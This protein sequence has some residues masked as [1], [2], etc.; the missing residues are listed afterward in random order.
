MS[1]FHYDMANPSQVANDGSTPMDVAVQVMYL[2]PRTSAAVRTRLD[3]LL[4]MD[5]ALDSCGLTNLHKIVMGITCL[6]L[7]RYLSSASGNSEV[8]VGD[9]ED[10]TPLLYASARGDGFAVET[11]LDAGASPNACASIVGSPLHVACRNGHLEVVV[12]LLQAGADVNARIPNS[13]LTPLHRTCMGEPSDTHIAIARILLRHGVDIEAVDGYQTT[14]LHLAAFRN[15][16][17]MAAFLVDAGANM[18][19]RDWE[20]TDTLGVSIISNACKAAA[21]LLGNMADTGNVDDEGCS[22]LHY[23]AR[24]ANVEM[25]E[26]FIANSHRMS[27]LDERLRDKHDKTPFQ[28]FMAREDL[29]DQL[30]EAFMRLLVAISEARAD[31]VRRTVGDLD[32]DDDSGPGEFYDALED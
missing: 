27:G 30:R 32:D 29:T 28:R 15:Q 11:L 6:D 8:N 5:L 3:T 9:S 25:M 20:G 14:P 16:H 1:P 18:N 12:K 17:S 13:L 7:R 26:L 23:V 31:Q 2:S 21:V 22:I 10:R 24:L 19:H 4:P